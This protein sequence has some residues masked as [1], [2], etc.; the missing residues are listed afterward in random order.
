[1][2]EHFLMR[3]DSHLVPFRRELWQAGL[4]QSQ[5][6]IVSITKNADSGDILLTFLVQ[7]IHVRQT[8]S[9][10]RHYER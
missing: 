7:V 6:T 2:F 1:M 9:Q 10:R 8:E 3:I 5:S 4:W